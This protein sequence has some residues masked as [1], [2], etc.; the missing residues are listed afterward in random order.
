MFNLRRRRIASYTRDGKRISNTLNHQA[1]GIYYGLEDNLFKKECGHSRGAS[2][3]WDVFLRAGLGQCID[4]NKD[5]TIPV[6]QIQYD[7][8]GNVIGC[9]WPT[10]SRL[11]IAGYRKFRICSDSVDKPVCLKDP[12]GN[13]YKDPISRIKCVAHPNACYDPV[14]RSKQNHTGNIDTQ[15][16]YSSQQL[17]DRRCKTYDKLAFNFQ[18]NRPL[19]N[20]QRGDGG[21]SPQGRC[22]NCSEYRSKCYDCSCNPV[23]VSDKACRPFSVQD[24]PKINRCIAVYKPNNRKFS[25]QG[26]VSA[27]SRLNRLKYQTILKSQSSRRK[28]LYGPPL[29]TSKFVNAV[30]GSMPV[31]LYRATAPQYKKWLHKSLK[32]CG[33]TPA[34]R[35]CNLRG[36]VQGRQIGGLSC[37]TATSCSASHGGRICLSRATRART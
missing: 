18:S 19:P 7:E 35:Q 31:S 13:L 25:Q 21:S 28:P 33:K 14:I 20:E 29:T 5:R 9:C 11:P 3:S 23:L 32:C 12:S 27:G 4:C 1:K 15:Y 8:E 30:G 16:N 34:G 6:S 37:G 17:L 26:A 36:S 2:H 10:P 22:K 24:N